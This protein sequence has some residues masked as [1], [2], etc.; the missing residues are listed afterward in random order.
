MTGDVV[1]VK[2]DPYYQMLTLEKDNGRKVSIK[3]SSG[4]KSRVN[5]D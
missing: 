3:T 5:Q 4:N 2:Y 1:H